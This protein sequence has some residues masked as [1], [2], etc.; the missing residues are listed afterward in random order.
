MGSHLCEPVDVVHVVLELG[1]ADRRRRPQLRLEVVDR[2]VVARGERGLVVRR[3][4]HPLGQLV[5]EL[6]DQL[7]RHLPVG[8]RRRVHAV[9]DHAAERHPR[10]AQL[11]V[12]E[13]RLLDRVV[14]R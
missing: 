8:P 7:V 5:A 1:D 4:G 10:L 11:A 6:L 2:R 12:E 9:D 3:V 14:L 13:D